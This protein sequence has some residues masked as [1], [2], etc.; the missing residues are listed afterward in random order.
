MLI[1]DMEGGFLD[2]LVAFPDIL[3]GVRALCVEMDAEKGSG[4]NDACHAKIIDAGFVCVLSASSK[5][6]RVYYNK[7][8]AHPIAT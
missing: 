2:V 7:D 8:N 1:V 5:K 4:K 6:H 3:S